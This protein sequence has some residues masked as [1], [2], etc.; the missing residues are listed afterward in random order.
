MKIS[1]KTFQ[2]F[3]YLA[4]SHFLIMFIGLITSAVWARYT[5]IEV[6]G[7]YQLLISFLSIVAIFGI[8][9][10]GLS[11]QLSAAK[12]K[13]GNLEILFKK[14]IL[15]SFVSSFFLILIGLYYQTINS[16]LEMAC[17]LYISSFIFP[18][19]NLKNIWES[20][21]TAIAEYKK[22]SYIQVLF[23]IVSL[24]S[25]I[26]SLVFIGNIYFVIII[27]F[28]TIALCN[29]LI[30]FY[31]KKMRQNKEEDY[32]LINY[33]Y[34]VSLSMIVPLLLSFDKFIISEYLSIKDVA[35]Y[36]VAIILITYIKSLYGIIN[37]LI[38]PRITMASTVHDAWTY[39]KPKM[40]LLVLVFFI[41]GIAGFFSLEYIIT[42][43]YSVKYT[44]SALYGK[45]L[46]LFTVIA[47]PATFLANILRA[48]QKLKFTYLYEIFNSGFKIIFFL[49][50][51]PIY[52]LWGIVYS[53]IIM[54]IFSSI[55]IF[56]YFYIELKKEKHVN[57]NIR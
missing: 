56:V 5:T 14:R 31:F 20:W 54:S 48:Q 16:D 6:F 47:I 43:I 30:I 8:P 9:G 34:K 35:I 23:A 57:K 29:A 46:W 42:F 25:L 40:S 53:T 1:K 37:R 21:L 38:T 28:S 55:L 36:S 19:Y 52:G 39:L 7:K 27:T 41:I 26:V 4:S 45:W 24:L 15:F 18:L 50:L 3:S 10:F 17:L 12:N 22:L 11:S 2:N 33:G 32:T 44:E 13:H 49:I 51:V